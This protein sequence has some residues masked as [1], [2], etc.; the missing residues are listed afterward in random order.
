[1]IYGIGTDICEILRITR[2]YER[3]ADRFPERILGSDEYLVYQ[4]R[5]QKVAQRGVKYLATRFAAKEAFSKAIGTGIRLPMTWRD[6]EILSEP[7]GKPCIKLHNELEALFEKNRLK[8]HVSI[9]DEVT[10]VMAFV[11]VEYIE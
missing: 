2:V 5:Q 7:S 8:A 9:T 3:H 10:F 6:C 11:V 4:A 1:M